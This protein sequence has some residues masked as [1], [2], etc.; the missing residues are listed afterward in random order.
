MLYLLWCL[1]KVCIESDGNQA[2]LGHGSHKVKEKLSLTP[3]E[4]TPSSLLHSLIYD[5]SSKHNIHNDDLSKM[6]HNM[7][8]YVNEFEYSIKSA[9]D[10]MCITAKNVSHC[11]E[12]A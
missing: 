6:L 2:K 3:F 1:K 9:Q 5:V 10:K 8:I 12:H 7:Q 11:D 4:I